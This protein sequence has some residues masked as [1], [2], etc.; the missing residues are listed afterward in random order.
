MRYRT[1]TPAP[2]STTPTSATVVTLMPVNGSVELDW[3]NCENCPYAFWAGV[4]AQAGAAMARIATH[5]T[6]SKISRLNLI[7]TP[8]GRRFAYRSAARG[9]YQPGPTD[10]MGAPP[11]I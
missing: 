10:G 4:A 9:S 7:K 5:I 2:I 11:A 6:P 3:L 1:A 8:R